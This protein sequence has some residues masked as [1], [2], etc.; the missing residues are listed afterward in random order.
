[1]K[2]GNISKLVQLE[3]AKHGARLLRN[4]IGAYQDDKTGAWVHYG[5]GGKGGSDL[6]GWTADGRF[7]AVEVKT[8]KGKTTPEQDAFLAAVRAA[9][10]VA[11]VVRCEED[12]RRL[13]QDSQ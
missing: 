11:G 5:V 2:E 7:L 4:N 10:G 12:V 1:M 6:I 13:L 3:A 8:P 9:G